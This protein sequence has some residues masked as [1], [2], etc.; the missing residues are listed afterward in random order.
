MSV[1]LGGSPI[2]GINYGDTPVKRVYRGSDMVFDSAPEVK[3]LGIR[4][5]S[6]ATETPDGNG[7]GP[8]LSWNFPTQPKPGNWLVAMTGWQ[9]RWV[10]PGWTRLAQAN[11]DYDQ[12]TDTQVLAM[13]IDETTQ[14]VFAGYG[15]EQ[16]PMWY[17]FEV[18]GINPDAATLPGNFYASQGWA[19][20]TRAIDNDA[21][22]VKADN[23]LFIVFENLRP[24]N[25]RFPASLDPIYTMLPPINFYNQNRGSYGGTAMVNQ[26]VVMPS[27][28]SSGGDSNSSY[29]VAQIRSGY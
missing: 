24:F 11:N 19:F 12:R 2:I 3:Q 13:K 28:R 16:S 4:Q 7:Q 5:Y 9:S 26:G 8:V 14:Q 22:L 15:W 29:C 18:E 6:A 17:L 21:R 20:Q 10:P 1:M 23:T 27:I 25:P